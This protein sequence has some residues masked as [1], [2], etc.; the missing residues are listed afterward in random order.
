M[1]KKGFSR[2]SS[3]GSSSS[4]EDIMVD[5]GSKGA[6]RELKRKNVFAEERQKAITNNR[7]LLK[8]TEDQIRIKQL[9]INK[10]KNTNEFKKC[11]ELSTELRS[12]TQRERTD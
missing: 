11:D 6:K 10:L 4:S 1:F 7:D 2:S 8:S 12:I 5:G 3:Q 9:R